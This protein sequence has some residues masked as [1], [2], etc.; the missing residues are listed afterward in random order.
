MP[1]KK[2]KHNN[3]DNLNNNNVK[4]NADV[5][6]QSEN[7]QLGDPNKNYAVK[8]VQKLDF[9]TTTDTIG[10]SI[11]IF[12]LAGDKTTTNT[13]GHPNFELAGDATTTDTMGHSNFELAAD[14][15]TTDTIGHLIQISNWQETTP[16]LLL[17]T[18]VM[19]ACSPCSFLLLLFSHSPQPSYT[20]AKGV[21]N[22]SL[23]NSRS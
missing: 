6:S 3:S 12:V 7:E 11:L 5:D 14:A 8:G 2:R 22:L 19:S 20:S 10:H 15:T 21:Y 17:S 9:H 1:T 23:L 16:R 18:Q 13:M 4:R